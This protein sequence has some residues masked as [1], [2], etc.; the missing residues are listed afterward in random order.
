MATLVLHAVPYWLA[1]IDTRRMDKDDPRRTEI[2]AYQREAVDALYAWASTP[3]I[4]T[5]FADLVPAEPVT[6]PPRPAPNASIEEWI[7][8]HQQMLTV[9]E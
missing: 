4:I 5:P 9:L 2:L 3:K 1:T 7:Y 8:Y 6:Q